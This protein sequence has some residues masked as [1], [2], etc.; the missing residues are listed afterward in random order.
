M[1]NGSDEY[2]SE[3]IAKVNAYLNNEDS[4]VGAQKKTP[5]FT[6]VQLANWFRV[7]NYFE[8]ELDW[9]IDP[10]TQMKVIK[11]L[12]IAFGV[13]DQLIFNSFRKEK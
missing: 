6:A 1:A 4:I 8:R 13:K 5:K 3:L 7:E 12:Y 2:S 11:L 9:D 10:I